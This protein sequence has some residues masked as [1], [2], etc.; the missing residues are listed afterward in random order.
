[1]FRSPLGIEVSPAD[2]IDLIVDQGL[3]PKDFAP[4]VT[5]IDGMD[6]MQWLEAMT[7]D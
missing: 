4:T 2:A 7:M 6:P 3:D 5:S 1:M